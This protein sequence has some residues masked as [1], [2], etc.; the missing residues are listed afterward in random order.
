MLVSAVAFPDF[1]LAIHILAAIV[2]FG[3]TFAY[4]LFAGAGARLDRRA[5]P[6]FHRMQQI[7]SRRITNPA[8]TIVLIAGIYLASDLHQWKNFYVQ[9]GLAAVVVLGGLEGAFM[10]PKTG[11]LAELAERDVAAAGTGE[12]QWSGEYQ[13]LFKRVGIVGAVQG[14]I[15]VITV[16]LM[17]THAGASTAP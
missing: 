3:V 2:G 17:A 5:I 8:L 7:I 6:W 4:P 9:W 15:V 16:F 14:L 10:I 13:A 11:Q 1:V 12:V